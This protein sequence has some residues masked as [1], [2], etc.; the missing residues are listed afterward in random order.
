M[1]LDPA[2]GLGDAD[3]HGVDL[4]GFD[5]AL[6][7][8]GNDVGLVGEVEGG[9]LYGFEQRREA[10]HG[11][12]AGVDERLDLVVQIDVADVVHVDGAERLCGGRGDDDVVVGIDAGVG[13]RG[14]EHGLEQDEEAAAIVAADRQPKIDVGVEDHLRERI[15]NAVGEIFVVGA[16]FDPEGVEMNVLGEGAEEGKDVDDL[17]GVGR[18]LGLVGDGGELRRRREV[19]GERDVLGEVEAAVGEGVLADVGAEG[20]A[21]G[22]CGGRGGDRGVDLFADFAADGGGG[23]EVGVVAA[24]VQGGGDVEERLAGFEG[25]GGAAGF[26]LGDARAWALP[27]CPALE[28]RGYCCCSRDRLLG[29]CRKKGRDQKQGY[30][31]AQREKC[32]VPV[33]DGLFRKDTIRFDAPMKFK[34]A[35]G[36]GGKRVTSS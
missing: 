22:A 24:G 16:M 7:D 34:G 27:E 10:L 31:E 13:G 3:V 26:G 18:Q 1:T 12:G 8:E 17:G 33:E 29:T 23:G 25:D 35:E 21:A 11:L 20:V 5:E 14:S 4:D 6:G 32:G 30:C 2:F 28:I 19:E 15:V 9:I 36:S